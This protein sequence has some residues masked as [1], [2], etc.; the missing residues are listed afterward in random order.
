[1]NKLRRRNFIV[2]FLG[3]ITLIFA[4][5]CN[6]DAE[7]FTPV[8]KLANTIYDEG[9][10]D[11]AAVLNLSMPQT[12]STPVIFDYSIQEASAKRGVDYIDQT[13]E[14]SFQPGETEAVLSIDLVND[15]DIE[16]NEAF[17]VLFTL[18]GSPEVSF[19]FEIIIENDDLTYAISSDAEG[20]ITPDNYN[21]MQLVWSDEFEGTSLNLDNWNYNIGNGC[22]EG[23]C[24]WGNE[25]LEVYTDDVDNVF[26]ESGKLTIRATEDSP[27]NYESG[28]ILTENKKVFKYGRIDIRAKLPEGQGI[29]PALWMLG[30][31]IGDVG[32]PKCG[33]IDI[34]EAV[35]QFPA[36]TYG[37]I[38]YDVDG[39]QFTSSSYSL[40]ENKK[41]SDQYHVFSIL[42]DRNKIIWYVDYEPFKTISSSSVGLTYPFNQEFFFIMNLAVGGLWPGPPDETTVFPQ[43]ME[44]DYIRVFQ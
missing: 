33:E 21:S 34:M 12:S 32:W 30:N 41:F 26:V 44:I 3:S 1:M 17:T 39:Y 11:G 27:G 16:L 35:G 8:L 29:W 10:I 9:N 25:E 24:G 20:F 31:N 37:T 15:E 18:E 5:G 13:G 42:W 22:N 7:N 4:T 6:N 28:R 38:H 14:I 2:A 23:I 40:N 19:N 36:V 43:Q